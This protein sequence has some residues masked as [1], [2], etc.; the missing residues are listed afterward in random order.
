MDKLIPDALAE[1][2]DEESAPAEDVRPGVQRD[3]TPE[4]IAEYV[5][6]EGL[7]PRE[8]AEPFG[9]YLHQAWNDYVEG[10][11]LTQ[12][13]LISGALEYWRGNS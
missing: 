6:T 12:R 10:E 5:I 7:L 9:Q 2:G 4:M 11:N 1:W 3:V 13:D 8:S